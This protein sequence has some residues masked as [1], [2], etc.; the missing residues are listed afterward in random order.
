M[1]AFSTDSHCDRYLRSQAA[2][3]CARAAR[4][5]VGGRRVVGICHP[6]KTA[7][8]PQTRGFPASTDCTSRARRSSGAT[9][10][11][12][13]PRT[14]AEI[15]LA[16][17]PVLGRSAVDA[18][19]RASEPTPRNSHRLPLSRAGAASRCRD[20]IVP[21]DAT[22]ESNSSGAYRSRERPMRGAH[23]PPTQPNGATSSK[24]R[25]EDWT[26]A[27]ET[28]GGADPTPVKAGPDDQDRGFRLEPWNAPLII[29]GR[30]IEPR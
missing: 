15:R 11:R 19:Y 14:W 22:T 26:S 3:A 9:N 2:R 28:A 10:G 24:G 27:P 30:L 5:T 23:R 13:G 29:A 20:W 18:A 1:V 8:Y 7:A 12:A 6:P 4:R 21:R 17:F 16:T 25:P